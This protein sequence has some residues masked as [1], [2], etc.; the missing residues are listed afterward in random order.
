MKSGSGFLVDEI[1]MAD[2]AVAE[3]LN[4]VLETDRTLLLS[5]KGSSCSSS[6]DGGM[7]AEN[8]VA[9]AKFRTFA[10]MNTG[11]D[12]GKKE[13]SP[14]LRNRFTEM[15]IPPPASTS[16][17]APVILSRMKLD[18]SNGASGNRGEKLAQA[19]RAIVDFVGWNL[20]SLPEASEEGETHLLLHRKA[21]RL[22][23]AMLPRGLSVLLKRLRV[24]QDCPQQ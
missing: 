17:Y 6:S 21:I 24:A 11:G 20:K 23:F 5:E 16:D 14:A 3:R 1:N 9:A 19:G 18:R 2:D 4:S 15:W 22:P 7:S 13:L 8:V 10:T 12:F